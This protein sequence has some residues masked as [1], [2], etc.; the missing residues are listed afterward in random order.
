MV[1]RWAVVLLA[2][3]VLAVAT[4]AQAER[5]V[6]VNGQRMSQDEIDQLE[7]WHCGPI[8]NGRFWLDR[9]TG[10]WGYA[11][12]PRARGNIRDNCAR[13]GRRPSLSERGMLY[14]PW[15]WVRK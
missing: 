10:T 14:Q 11:G 4:S 8:P 7:R 15:D 3:A 6:W 5:R 1:S 2:P 13:P 12:D 9:A